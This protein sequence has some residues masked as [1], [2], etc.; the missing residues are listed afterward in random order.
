[1][2][3]RNRVNKGLI[4]SNFILQKYRGT[5][6]KKELLEELKEELRED[7][8]REKKEEENSNSNAVKKDIPISG[9]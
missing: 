7:R 1:M 4:L 3:F 2:H 9:R 8:K 6:N 5:R